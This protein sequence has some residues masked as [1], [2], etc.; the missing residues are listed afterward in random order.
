MK[1]RN[2]HFFFNQKYFYFY[3]KRVSIASHCS[4][5][6]KKRN[7]NCLQESQESQ[8]QPDFPLQGLGD[9]KYGFSV[10]FF[11]YTPTY[12]M[13]EEYTLSLGNLYVAKNFQSC[14][15]LGETVNPI[16][17]DIYLIFEVINLSVFLLIFRLL[18]EI[19]N[20]GNEAVV[21]EVGSVLR[22]VLLQYGQKRCKLQSKSFRLIATEWFEVQGNCGCGKSTLNG[23]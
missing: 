16:K 14:T 4:C 8:A 10:V 15:D 11:L 23:E 2:S 7:Q 22:L 21:H 5:S 19:L 1:K 12:I 17:H 18:S 6:E 13:A 20:Y 3:T 9:F